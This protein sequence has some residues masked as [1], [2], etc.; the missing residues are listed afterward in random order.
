MI[1]RNQHKQG[2]KQQKAVPILKKAIE[3]LVLKHHG[4][5]P[6]PCCQSRDI[7]TVSSE[8]S[9]SLGVVVV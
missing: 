1:G 8:V 2:T 5:A 4:L 3:T 9:S 7:G 6:N